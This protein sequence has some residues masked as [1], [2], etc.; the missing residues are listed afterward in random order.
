MSTQETMDQLDD[1]DNQPDAPK[2]PEVDTQVDQPENQTPEGEEV[3]ERPEKKT[4]VQ[5]RIDELTRARHEAERQAAYYRGLAERGGNPSAPAEKPVT[6]PEKPDPSQYSDYGQYM[7]ELADWKAEQKV[8]KAFS[9]REQQQQE[10][11]QQELRTQ[12]FATYQERAQAFAADTPDFA[13]VISAAEDVPM[14]DSMQEL[15]VSSEKGPQIAYHMAMNPDVAHRIAQMTPLMAAREF[16]RLEAQLSV[17]KTEATPPPPVKPSSAPKPITPT[18]GTG[19]QFTKDP[20]QMS[21]AE[22]FASNRK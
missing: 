21:D 4:T 6:A 18:R 17:P 3:A 8:S 1:H 22:W 9:E 20:A 10:R 14:T 15:I 7:E 13:D 2:Q 11:T 5:R 16:G 19:G 12:S